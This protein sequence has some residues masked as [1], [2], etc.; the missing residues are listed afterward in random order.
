MCINLCEKK[1]QFI[2]VVV[3]AIKIIHTNR[4]YCRKSRFSMY[5]D[6]CIRYPDMCVF[7]YPDVCIECLDICAHQVPDMH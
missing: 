3:I 1:S 2:A 6:V 7:K 5:S 4:R